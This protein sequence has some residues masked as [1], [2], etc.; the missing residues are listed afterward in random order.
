MVDFLSGL[1]SGSIGLDSFAAVS[2]DIGIIFE[3]N[4]VI[5][6]VV[7]RR[8]RDLEMDF[9]EHFV[10]GIPSWGGCLS[11]KLFAAFFHNF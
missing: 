7:G 5:F 1:E 4:I 10:E 6:F 8:V 11:N 3:D 9:R 2:I